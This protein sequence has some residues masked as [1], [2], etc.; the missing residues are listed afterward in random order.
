MKKL[1]LLVGYILYGIMASAQSMPFVP[2]R[3]S[4]DGPVLRDQIDS[5]VQQAETELQARITQ[6]LVNLPDS[7]HSYFRYQ[8]R[9]TYDFTGRILFAYDADGNLI[10][11]TRLDVFSG[12]GARELITYGA[13]ATLRRAIF[14]TRPSSQGQWSD[15]SQV[16]RSRAAAG[17]LV[18]EANFDWS[19]RW[20]R[21]NPVTK[22]STGSDSTNQGSE[23]I[24][25]GGDS[26]NLSWIPQ[27]R[28]LTYPGDNLRS[29]VDYWSS[30]KQT[31]V[32]TYRYEQLK[33][34]AG[35]L[36]QQ[37]SVSWDPSVKR[38]RGYL[39]KFSY[40]SDNQI[41]IRLN[42]TLDGSQ[43]NGPEPWIPN[44]QNFH[45]YKDNGQLR[46][47]ITESWSEPQQSWSLSFREEF[48]FDSLS[49]N[50]ST[51]RYF[52]SE[53]LWI[54]S[55]RQVRVLDINGYDRIST[56]ETWNTQLNVWIPQSRNLIAYDPQGTLLA[57]TVQYWNGAGW[58][59]FS[60]I[61]YLYGTPSQPSSGQISEVW[62]AGS[63]RWEKQNRAEVIYN[64]QGLLLES[65]SELWNGSQWRC[66]YCL[67]QNLDTA[68]VILSTYADFGDYMARDTFY[69]SLR[70][71]SEKAQELN[72]C[73]LENPHRFYSPVY[74]PGLET[75]QTYQVSLTDMQGRIVMDMNISGGDIF[76]LPE[77]IAGGVY[78]FRVRSGD[79][80]VYQQKIILQP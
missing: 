47:I 29:Y 72:T 43:I 75:D 4:W 24:F 27:E 65:R 45:Y 68:G 57:D 40:R 69:Y 36:R 46:E 44:T 52:R 18:E 76:Q 39:S 33:D 21:W 37:L 54:P 12:A 58:V 63:N 5:L 67:R 19:P 31:W 25:Y 32:P 78:L 42:E 10:N 66:A 48:L 64:S 3:P 28:R 80:E 51:V 50:I 16:I 34:P 6:N 62:N 22:L 53:F 60:A 59:N 79:T 2:A 15:Q 14:Q 77:R 74:C 30:E 13:D 11:Q 1:L 23:V 70:D 38:Y 73:W 8:G 41:D 56:Y 49:R 7:V 71:V 61:Q 17:N 35:L 20:K 55:E 9:N 26:L